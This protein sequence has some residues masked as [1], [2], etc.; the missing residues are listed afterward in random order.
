MADR[1]LAAP[2][3]AI[4]E[5][6]DGGG[7]WML[8]RDGG[9]FAFGDAPYEGSESASPQAPAVG[10]SP[11][12]SGQGYVVAYADGSVQSFGDQTSFSS[13]LPGEK[14]NAPIVGVALDPYAQGAW[15]V[16]A[17]GGVFSL[18]NAPFLGSLAGHRLAGPITGVAADPGG[19]GYWLV[20]ADGGVFAFG[21]A[22]FDGSLQSLGVTPSARIVGITST[23]DGG[24]YWLVGADGGVFA[25]GD[26]P[27][28]GSMGGHRLAEPVVGGSASFTLPPCNPE[29]SVST[30]KSSYAGGAPV[31]ISLT[32]H[33]PSRYGCA[34]TTAATTGCGPAA[35]A[36]NETGQVVWENFANP[37]NA[38]YNCPAGILNRPI[39]GSADET[40]TQVWHQ[41]YCT[42]SESP[43]FQTN[44]NCPQTQVPPG[45]YTISG[46]WGTNE[47]APPTTIMIGSS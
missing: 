39:P 6:P 38:P 17:D 47:N 29:F 2:V 13:P 10:I 12:G 18:G 44:P 34:D 21:A 43:S 36:S 7:Y 30:D 28:L 3:A 23:A 15:L 14:L 40:G 9:I 46:S 8:G 11:D 42:G 24:G 22:M 27:Y 45:N 35:S 1:H 31:T 16:G 20:G 19:S 37:Q 41:D 4:G 33:N 5:S 32:Y 26:A 25:F